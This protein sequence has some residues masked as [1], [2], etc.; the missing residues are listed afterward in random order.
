MGLTENVEN[1]L[2]PAGQESSDANRVRDG[3][4]HPRNRVFWIDFRMYLVKICLVVIFSASGVEAVPKPSRRHKRAQPVNH[5]EFHILLALADSERHGYGIMQEVEEKSEGTVRL[6]P[7]TL[8]G[9]IK[10]MLAAGLIEESAKRPA[11]SDDKRR[12]CY[13]RLTHRGRSIVT[14]EAKRLAGLVR[15]AAA[16]RLVTGQAVPA[17]GEA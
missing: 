17:A 15:V 2:H 3:P 11:V 9:A 8:Y 4:V 12:R 14:E 13:Y 16:K 1:P 7:G 5:S 10:R 6:G